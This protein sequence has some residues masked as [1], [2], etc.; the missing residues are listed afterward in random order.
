MKSLS[1]AF[2]GKKALVTYIAAGDP[3]LDTTAYLLKLLDTE[4]VDV[5]E[6]GIPFSDP[7]ADGPVIQ[8]ASQRALAGGAT[9]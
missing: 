6:V 7:L 1:S 9:L 5:L 2:E 4:G 8:Q 3:D